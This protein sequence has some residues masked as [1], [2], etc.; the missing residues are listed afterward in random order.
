MPGGICGA[1]FIDV[2]FENVIKCKLGDEYYALDAKARN[3]ISSTFINE[4]KMTLN[5][6]SR[7]KISFI[8]MKNVSDNPMEGIVN[9]RLELGL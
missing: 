3:K 4:I 9:E 7:Q 5:H 8:G 1:A 2:A 6:D